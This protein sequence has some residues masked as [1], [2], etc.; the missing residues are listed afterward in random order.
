MMNALR[1]VDGVERRVFAERTGLPIAAIAAR[2]DRAVQTGLL[3]DNHERLQPT[4][5]GQRFLNDLL[6][7]FLKPG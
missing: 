2:L 4:L 7:L 3:A 5:K 6:E 1:L